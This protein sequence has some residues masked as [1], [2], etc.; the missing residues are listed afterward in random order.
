MMYRK[1]GT[2]GY[3][4]KDNPVTRLFSLAVFFM[5]VSMAIGVLVVITRQIDS[6]G[7]EAV[8]LI[9][10]FICIVVFALKSK[11]SKVETVKVEPIKKTEPIKEDKEAEYEA[12][13]KEAREK[14]Y[15][16]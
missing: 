14:G 6:I 7:Q 8:Y 1:P 2:W 9:A 15:I 10:L 12:I 4:L 11:P 5:L 3:Q 13:L 16:K